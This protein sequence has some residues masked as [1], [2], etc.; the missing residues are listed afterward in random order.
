MNQR[1]LGKLMA[2][3]NAGEAVKDATL[4]IK[5][6]RDAVEEEGARGNQAGKFI[7]MEESDPRSLETGRREA[8]K[9]ERMVMMF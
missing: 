8:R 7:Y 4:R 1:K 6:G 2:R 3:G 5:R 9:E